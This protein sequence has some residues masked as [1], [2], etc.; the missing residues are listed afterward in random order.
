MRFAYHD[1]WRCA[2]AR[3]RELLPTDGP[4]HSA[5]ISISSQHAGRRVRMVGTTVGLDD[6]DVAWCGVATEVT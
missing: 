2:L 5:D 6:Q 3:V 4:M 1:H